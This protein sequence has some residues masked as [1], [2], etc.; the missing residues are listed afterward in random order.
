MLSY[1][2]K[3]NIQ[4]AFA[5]FLGMIMVFAMLSLWFVFVAWL[6]TLAWDYILVDEATR[7]ITE[8]WF[9]PLGLWHAFVAMFLTTLF[10][11]GS[12]TVTT[13]KE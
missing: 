6:A 2:T 1:R 7:I 4:G 12:A 3:S 13:K 10:L 5:A 8:N 9:K 11:K